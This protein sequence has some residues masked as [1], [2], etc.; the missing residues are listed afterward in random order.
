M[1]GFLYLRGL[2]RRRYLDPAGTLGVWRGSASVSR[3]QSTKIRQSAMSAPI[4]P[5]AALTAKT[6]SD[7]IIRATS[8]NTWTN[9]AALAL[10]AAAAGLLLFKNY[11]GHAQME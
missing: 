10:V 8:G 1:R 2:V 11:K 7:T 5:N 4:R 6:R 9:V 3:P